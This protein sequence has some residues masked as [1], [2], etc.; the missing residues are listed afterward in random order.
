VKYRI[1]LVVLMALCLASIVAA[2]TGR[3]ELVQTLTSSNPSVAAGFGESLAI[4]DALDRWAMF[5]GSPNLTGRGR[6]E[7]FLNSG[8]QWEPTNCVLLQA[9]SQNSTGFGEALSTSG[10]G[11]SALVV[12]GEPYFDATG[13]FTD[14]GRVAVFK[15][16]VTTNCHVRVATLKA[17]VNASNQWFGASVDVVVG[18]TESLIIVGAPTA[19]NSETGAA[20]IYSST[21]GGKKWTLQASLSATPSVSGT[22]FGWD[23]AID[24]L[25]YAPTAVVGAMNQLDGANEYGAMYVYRRTGGTWPQEQVISPGSIYNLT[26][27][28]WSVDVAV[29]STRTFVIGSGACEA[30][31]N[32]NTAQRIFIYERI[33]S[34]RAVTYQEDMVVSSKFP[35]GEDL[36]LKNQPGN[37]EGFYAGFTSSDYYYALRSRV[38]QFDW[39]EVDTFIPGSAGN[40][41]AVTTSIGVNPHLA[42]GQSNLATAWISAPGTEEFE[43]LGN[44]GF[45]KGVKP[46]TG[47]AMKWTKTNVTNDDRVCVSGVSCIFQFKGSAQENSLLT[48]LVYMNNHSFDIGDTL[49]LSGQFRTKYA[50]PDLTMTL[51]ITANGIDTT[52]NVI[53]DAP[54]SGWQT[55]STTSYTLC[56]V[57]S[58]IV[59]T[60]NNQ[61]KGGTIKLDNVSLKLAAGNAGNCPAAALPL[62]V[63]P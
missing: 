43:L 57:P 31:G 8:S 29:S 21:N 36:V 22:G 37:A 20:Y 27:F 48:Q 12:V 26:Q 24:G 1:L 47:I 3:Y 18:A 55:L 11:L 14:Q 40:R 51:T 60:I 63:T 15:Y 9:G 35:I 4:G 39:P 19:N 32:V 16:D 6:V 28:G 33:E 42:V 41:I 2:Q 45:G 30:C 44:G 52:R 34:A 13:G 10:I 50:T 58:N 53:L 46:G 54:T 23:V 38:N 17:P 62:P 56:D 5:V 59:V 61:S 7:R 49:T 25:D